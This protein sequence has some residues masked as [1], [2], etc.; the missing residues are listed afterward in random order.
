MIILIIQYIH[1]SGLFLLVVFQGAVQ[2]GV[3]FCSVLY[4]V[5]VLDPS[6]YPCLEAENIATVN[7][8]RLQY[9]LENIT[10]PVADWIVRF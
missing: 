9:T 4:E 1:T 6:C 3:L 5:N 2:V 8:C 7:R 10:L